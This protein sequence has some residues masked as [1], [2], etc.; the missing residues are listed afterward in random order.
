[1]M[2]GTGGR[3]RLPPLFLFLLHTSWLLWSSYQQDFCFQP[4]LLP[5]TP[6]LQPSG[7]VW[8]LGRPVTDWDQAPVVLHPV[9]SLEV[10]GAGKS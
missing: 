8:L 10:Q 7:E 3:P 2:D 5:G 6:C 9:L 1:M 4:A